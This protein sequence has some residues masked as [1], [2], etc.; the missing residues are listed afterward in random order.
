MATSDAEATSFPWLSVWLFATAVI[1]FD[2]TFDVSTMSSEVEEDS[3]VS[4]PDPTPTEDE[5]G[6]ND[7]N[8]DNNNNDNNNYNNNNNNNIS[9]MQNWNCLSSITNN[10]KY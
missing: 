10:N 7:N 9:Y 4:R 3:I 6:L 1:G 2:G 8:N 5:D